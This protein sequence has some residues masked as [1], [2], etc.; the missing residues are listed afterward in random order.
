MVKYPLIYVFI[1]IYLLRNIHRLVIAPKAFVLWVVD[2]PEP[3]I[4]RTPHNT[5]RWQQVINPA[6]GKVNE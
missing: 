1:R 5:H 6:I 2:V 4:V 3:L